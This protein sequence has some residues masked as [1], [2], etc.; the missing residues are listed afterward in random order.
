MIVLLHALLKSAI[1]FALV[2]AH[3]KPF[4]LA[5]SLSK[6]A[7]TH[8]FVEASRLQD[9]KRACKDKSVHRTLKANNIFFIE[10]KRGDRLSVDS[11]V[12]AG[13]K[14]AARLHG[15]VVDASSFKSRPA[16]KDTLA[17]LVFSSGTSGL[18]K[19]N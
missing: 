8:L 3:S 19:G 12:Q 16:N 9:A 4:E 5:H 1:P 7:C 10:G 6:A 15:G 2:S 11:L 13:Q 18:P 14:R 17:Y